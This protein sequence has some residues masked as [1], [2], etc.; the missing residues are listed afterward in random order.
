MGVGIPIPEPLS[1]ETIAYIRIG[2]F[3]FLSWLGGYMATKA[4]S[5]A[6]SLIGFILMVACWYVGRGLAGIFSIIGLISGS[7]MSYREEQKWLATVLQKNENAGPEEKT[8]QP[9]ET[10]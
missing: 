10:A 6:G 7:Y 9:D 4:K 5:T 8:Q 2:F 3:Y 1:V